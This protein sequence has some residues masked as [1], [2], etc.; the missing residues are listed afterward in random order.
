[1]PRNVEVTSVNTG[2]L[3][4]IS[5]GPHQLQADEP[6]EAGGDDSGPNPYELLLAAL[7]SCTSM[8]IQM[9]A[10]RKRWPL[11]IVRVRLKH[12]KIHAEDCDGCETKVGFV[13]RIEREIFLVGELTDEQRR[14]L[15]EIANKC[16]V[17]RTLTSEIRIETYLDPI[18]LPANASQ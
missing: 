4:N 17:H 14:R 9:Y 5:I 1:M 6:F 18:A 12:G 16:P 10:K 8:T 2:C 11:D 15:L 7:G 3:Q 13:D